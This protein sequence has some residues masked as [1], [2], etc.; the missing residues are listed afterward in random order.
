[1][2]ILGL[3]VSMASAFMVRSATPAALA[4]AILAFAIAAHVPTASVT[5]S[6][7]ISAGALMLMIAVLQDT[8]RM[9]YRDELTGLPSRRALN[10]W[11]LSP[12]RIYTIAMADV[13]HFKKFN[14]TYG[15]DLG[16]QV[17]KMVAARLGRVNGGGKAFRYGGEEFTI[18]FPGRSIEESL[19][20]LES[21]RG[22]IEAYRIALRDADRPRKG[23]GSKRQRGGW[24]GKDSVSV[25]VS[26]GVAERSD[27][28]ASPQAVIEAADRALYRAKD[29]GRNRVSR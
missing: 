7:F 24:R 1:M 22:E 14:D 5:F 6:I 27:R 10:E 26:M 3:L 16:D 28:N 13:D 29:K 11:M 25:T 20:F 18:V 23:K 21:L 19:P 8:F 15:H 17:L 12:G 4:G 9:A 2:I